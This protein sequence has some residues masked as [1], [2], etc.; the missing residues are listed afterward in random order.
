MESKR[1]QIKV[2]LHL[3]MMYMSTYV[4]PAESPQTIM[5]E[6]SGAGTSA[7]IPQTPG[8][9]SAGMQTHG[10]GIPQMQTPGSAS[11]CIPQTPGSVKK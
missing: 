6:D 5:G 2:L 7:S 8:F 3:F 10:T 9:V 11:T 4:Y 1:T